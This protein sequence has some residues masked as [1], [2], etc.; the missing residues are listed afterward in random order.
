MSLRTFEY[1][2]IKLYSASSYRHIVQVA[3][4]EEDVNRLMSGDNVLMYQ[5]VAFPNASS[6]ASVHIGKKYN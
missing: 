5:R 3:V 2:T 6:C 4:D 1:D